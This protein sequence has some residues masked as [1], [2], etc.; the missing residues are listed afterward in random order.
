MNFELTPAQRALQAKCREFATQEVAP[1][2]IE[3]DENERFPRDIFDKMGEAGILGMMLPQDFGGLGGSAVD[4][5]VAG[6]EMA[7]ADG[8]VCLSFGAHS[9]LCA[10]NL[11]TNGNASQKAKYLPK[12]ASGE[13]MGALAM[14]EPHSGSDVL[15]LATR[16]EKQPGGGYLLNGRKTY[17][18]NGSEADLILV[19]ARTSEEMG[20]HGISAFLIETS[21]PGFKVEH[22]F[23]KM[24]MKSSPTA[25]IA[26]EN[27]EVPEEN[28]LGVENGGLMILMSG[29]DVERATGGALGVGLARAAFEMSLQHAQ[30]RKQFGKP[31]LKQQMI[32][33]MLSDMLTDIHAARLLTFMAAAKCDSGERAT[34]EASMCK[35]FAAEMAE[36]VT[37]NAI[38]VHGGHG[39][40]RHAGV[41][42]LARDAKLLTIGGGSS[43]VQRMILMKMM[44]GEWGTIETALAERPIS[45]D[46][47]VDPWLQEAMAPATP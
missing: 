2:A 30:H 9:V 47:P 11:A 45:Y 19:Y 21:W 41:E 36:R 40:M 24:G 44:T 23:K 28:L 6:E 26:F 16:A 43:Q 33:Q 17:I 5:C 34:M 4:F 32:G 37:M 42:R 20:P 15:S 46:N 12:L 39:Y 31:I 18:T 14:T 3:N 25:Q 10:N 22:T 7:A 1:Y 38:Q 27:V 13:W 29:L 8:G 35:L